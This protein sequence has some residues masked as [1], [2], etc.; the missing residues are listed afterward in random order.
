MCYYSLVSLSNMVEQRCGP[1]V[2]L[3][4][5]EPC[6]LYAG[7]FFNSFSLLLQRMTRA[8]A[9]FHLALGVVFVGGTLVAAG[10]GESLWNYANKGLCVYFSLQCA[11]PF[12]TLVFTLFLVCR[13]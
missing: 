2:C 3:E 12:Q 13:M 6:G 4:E 1:R 11:H 9:Y 8:D 10:A 7:W 5:K